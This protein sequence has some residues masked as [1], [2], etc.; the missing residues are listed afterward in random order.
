[1]LRRDHAE[2]LED[3]RHAARPT[4]RRDTGADR[5][6]K[7][8]DVDD[9]RARRALEM[10]RQRRRESHPAEMHRR[11]E[12]VDGHAADH[13]DARAERPARIE[14]REA[15]RE[16]VE[17]VAADRHAFRQAGEHL[18]RA[19]ERGGRPI[20]GRREQDVQRCP[21]RNVSLDR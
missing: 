15:R 19:A 20:G 17:L 5:V 12:V 3:V 13:L 11:R 14:G 6:A 18:D 4:P 1:M 21:R 16:D 2:P 10:Q 7:A 9:V 8:E